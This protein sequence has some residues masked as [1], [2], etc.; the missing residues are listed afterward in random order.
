MDLELDGMTA[1]VTGAG[2]G[3][4]RGIA[5]VLAREG[6]AVVVNDLFTERAAAVAREITAAGRRWWT[7]AA[8]AC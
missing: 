8:G 7:C 6:A 2:Q 4:G 5:A 3:V 1:L